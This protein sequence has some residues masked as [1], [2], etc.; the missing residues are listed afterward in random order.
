MQSCAGNGAEAWHHALDFENHAGRN[1]QSAHVS[2]DAA[3]LSDHAS[4]MNQFALP[5]VEHSGF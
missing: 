5:Q 3:G 4:L 2:P 1:Y